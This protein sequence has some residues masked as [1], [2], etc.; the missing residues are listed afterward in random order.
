[1][2]TTITCF[3]G[4]N[5]IGGNKILL[6]DDGKRLLLDFGMSFGRS[7][8]YFD[9]VFLTER[10]GR[11]LLDPLSLGLVPPLRGLLRDDLVPALH[12]HDFSVSELPSAGRK[13][14]TRR[15]ASLRAETIEGFWRHWQDRFMEA[16]R[17]LRD[18]YGPPVDA[19]LISHAHQDHISDMEYLRSDIPA[20]S[21]CMTAFISKVLL[22]IGGG[23]GAAYIRPA[24]LSEHGILRSD[25]S[26]STCRRPW[27]FLD[28]VPSGTTDDDTLANP[29][30][31][32]D[33]SATKNSALVLSPSHS[34][35]GTVGSWHIKWWPVDH[36]IP[37]AAA[38]AV[39]TAAGW[40]GYS[41][42]IR[43]HGR[44]GAMTWEAAK[45]IAALRPVALL[46]EGTRLTVPNATTELEVYDNCL[47]VVQAAD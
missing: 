43:F 3:G 46:C 12:A 31:F 44:H 7:G 27:H 20:A 34:F 38:F 29:Q 19:V 41:G 14:A 45:E 21:T 26:A 9:G 32:W 30:S 10:W 33:A 22:D 37:G 25:R 35:N 4:A 47:R 42:D 5:E 11:G 15:V 23:S 40:V 8:R 36:S 16:Y 28:R 24:A 13:R 6:E 17:D 2:S 1:M 18:D 39:E